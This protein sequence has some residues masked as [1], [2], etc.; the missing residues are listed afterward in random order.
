MSPAPFFS[1]SAVCAK[2]TVSSQVDRRA[3]INLRQ[4]F[5]P[6]KRGRINLLFSEFSN[7]FF[8]FAFFFV[9]PFVF[10]FIWL[11]MQCYDGGW[12]KQ[13]RT[14][15]LLLCWLS[16]NL[17][18]LPPPSLGEFFG[19]ISLPSSQKWNSK[20]T[21]IAHLF[22]M[23]ISTRANNPQTSTTMI[24]HVIM[25]YPFYDY[26]S[27]RKAQEATFRWQKKQLEIWM[28][29]EIGKVLR[30]SLSRLIAI[31]AYNVNIHTKKSFSTPASCRCWILNLC[32]ASIQCR[33]LLAR[34]AS[35][36]AHISELTWKLS[37]IFWNVVRLSCHHI[38]QPQ[39]H[40]RSIKFMQ[41]QLLFTW[42]D[43]QAFTV[44][45]FCFS[46]QINN[47][48]QIVLRLNLII[49]TFFPHFLLCCTESRNI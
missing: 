19:K 32:V 36:W 26:V 7:N 42:I 1:P 24:K 34:R 31:G 21:F 25:L 33:R 15:F 30:A 11:I 23:F 12:E 5:I 10:A 16:G 38:F 17:T 37:E 9:L 8:F 41:S 43:S 28:S 49:K 48:Q 22:P 45:V 4:F 39:H 3:L 2:R 27:Q 46:W 6:W 29:T 14:D 44:E 40:T 18:F 13:R 35:N 20:H 47:Q